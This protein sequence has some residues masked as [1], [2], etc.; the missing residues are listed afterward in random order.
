[1]SE[2]LDDG[3]W[4]SMQRLLQRLVPERTF[5]FIVKHPPNSIC[6]R[7]EDTSFIIKA[8]NKKRVSIAFYTDAPNVRSYVKI[9]STEDCLRVYQDQRLYFFTQHGRSS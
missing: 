2:E 9:I 1:M 4:E 5:R 7:R 3:V 6:V 8:L